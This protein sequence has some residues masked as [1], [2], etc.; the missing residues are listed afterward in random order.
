MEPWSQRRNHFM[1]RNAD[2]APVTRVDIQ[3]TGSRAISRP[4]GTN[5]SFFA[6]TFSASSSSPVPWGAA[7]KDLPPLRETSP[8]S[9]PRPLKASALAQTDESNPLGLPRPSSPAY[10]RSQRFGLR[11]VTVHYDHRLRE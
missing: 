7:R 8:N 5:P 10:S 9:S 11:P 6:T 4:P 2:W 3:P 1:Q